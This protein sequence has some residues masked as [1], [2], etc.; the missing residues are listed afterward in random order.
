MPVRCVLSLDGIEILDIL[1]SPYQEEFAS[2]LFKMRGR[3]GWSMTETKRQLM[4]LHIFGAMMVYMVVGGR[5]G[6]RHRSGLC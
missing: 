5:S 1:K 6:G 3:K 4:N 2:E